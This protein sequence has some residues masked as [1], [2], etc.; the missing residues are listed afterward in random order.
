MKNIAK[1]GFVLLSLLF[2]AFFITG[3]GKPNTLEE[4]INS[5]KK[6]KESIESLETDSLKIEVKDNLFTYIFDTKN[7]GIADEEVAKSSIMKESFE[8]TLS[9]SSSVYENLA[10]Q[11]EDTTGISGIQVK[12][13]YVYGDYVIYEK[14]FSAK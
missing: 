1:K 5:N 9:S 14:T 2:L 8:K 3:C 12:V 7:L 13:K 6:E 4:Y 11:Y 10:K